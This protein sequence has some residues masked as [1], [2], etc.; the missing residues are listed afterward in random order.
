MVEVRKGAQLALR[1][2]HLSE[3]QFIPWLPVMAR[4]DPEFSTPIFAEPRIS[5]VASITKRSSLYLDLSLRFQPHQYCSGA[6]WWFTGRLGGERVTAG[7]GKY[8]YCR[9]PLSIPS[10]EEHRMTPHLQTGDT[11]L[12]YWCQQMSQ[13]IL[14]ETSLGGREK[15]PWLSWSVPD[16]FP[17]WAG[18]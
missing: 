5:L 4:S 2:I 11:A 14:L 8:C 6:N 3:R 16:C 7:K 18:T 9:R 13:K 12:R 1:R 17:P 15:Q 10:T